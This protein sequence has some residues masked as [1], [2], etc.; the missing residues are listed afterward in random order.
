MVLVATVGLKRLSV[1]ARNLEGGT[2]DG[3]RRSLA[4]IGIGPSNWL[5]RL[6]KTSDPDYL[7]TQILS[8]KKLFR[9]AGLRVG[10]QSVLVEINSFSPLFAFALV[11]NVLAEDTDS[12]IVPF[13]A[14]PRTARMM[15]QNLY[16]F[17]LAIAF[18][19]NF[20]RKAHVYKS[21]GTSNKPIVPSFARRARRK[22]KEI[23]AHFFDS[24]PTKTDLENFRVGGVLVGDLFYDTYLRQ[25]KIPTIDLGD[26]KF[27]RFFE[28]SLADSL[29][30]DETLSFQPIKAVVASHSCFNY[31]LPLR[32]AM[33]YGVPAF[34]TGEA[35]LYRLSEERVFI[36]MEILDYPEIFARLTPRT[37]NRILA[38]GDKLLEQRFAG[39][40]Y[41]GADISSSSLQSYG[42]QDISERVLPVTSVP[43]VLIAPHAF[44]DGPHGRGN[45]L[46]PDFWEWL[47]FMGQKSGE[48]S[49][50]WYIKNHP[51]VFRGDRPIIDSFVRRF[52][53]LTLLPEEVTHHQLITE[54]I[55]VVVTVHGTIGFE[56]ALQ[57]VPVINASAINPHIR[58][59]FNHH[60]QSV[61]ELEALLENL[62]SIPRPSPEDKQ[63]AREY[64][65]VKNYLAENKFLMT[66]LPELV[67]PSAE[68]FDVKRDSLRIRNELG[69]TL[70]E[71]WSIERH[72]Q[73]T[74][75]IRDFVR[76]GKY[77]FMLARLND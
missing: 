53:S 59:S 74:E 2:L 48:T 38:E 25:E 8:N 14:S 43:K 49:Y 66:G 34:V 23:A 37:R 67:R 22:S 39:K 18:Q 55:T 52:P 42:T 11:S 40:I 47:E 3:V 36:H 77:M 30:W 54:G 19:F 72:Q 60:P 58:Y 13:V 65:A 28:A 68:L 33:K 10:T 63:Q 15:P 35:F 62:E 16:R 56:Y 45:A 21:F 20:I 5:P 4:F 61:S 29:F 69:Q 57:G 31:A 76:S 71:N 17:A 41:P 51:D 46:F 75:E 24:G 1:L 64:F 12:S 9:A 50:E 32:F 27:R 6:Q 26:P 7:K 73:M 44:S 70:V